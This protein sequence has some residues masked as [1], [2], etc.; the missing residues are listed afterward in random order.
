MSK[1]YPELFPAGRAP[2]QPEPRADE[3]AFLRI[4]QTGKHA[5]WNPVA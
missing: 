1:K 2:S 4:S 5:G 3:R